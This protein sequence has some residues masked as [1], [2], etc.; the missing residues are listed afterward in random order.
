MKSLMI[1]LG[2]LSWLN[3]S[4]VGMGSERSVCKLCA[5]SSENVRLFGEQIVCETCEKK[6]KEYFPDECCVCLD[7][8]G[9]QNLQKP[10]TLLDLK[11]SHHRVVHTGDRGK[12]VLSE[13][14]LC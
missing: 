12:E 1:V 9:V 13:C 3:F 7:P 10:L 8:I 5:H 11:F 4:V 6:A 14:R 2:L